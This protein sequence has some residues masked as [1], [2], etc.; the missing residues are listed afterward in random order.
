M[1]ATDMAP[2]TAA[3]PGD[4]PLYRADGPFVDALEMVQGGLAPWGIAAG[5]RIDVG[6]TCARSP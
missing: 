3:K 6:E 2:C 5:S 4:C 1:S